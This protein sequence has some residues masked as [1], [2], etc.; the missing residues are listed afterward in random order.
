F[1]CCNERSRPRARRRRILGRRDGPAPWSDAEGEGRD[2][3]G[4]EPVGLDCGPD[5]PPGDGRRRGRRA[6][7]LAALE[8]SRDGGWDRS[9]QGEGGRRGPAGGAAVG[10]VAGARR[11]RPGRPAGPGARRGP[12]ITPTLETDG[13]RWVDRPTRRA[14]PRGAGVLVGGRGGPYTSEG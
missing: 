14:G 12:L 2:A 5:A 13:L 9:Q 11:R 7:D 3:D 6:G 4:A 1:N 8:R 10:S